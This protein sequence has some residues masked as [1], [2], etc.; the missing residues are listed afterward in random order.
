MQRCRPSFVLGYWVGNHARRGTVPGP[1]PMQQGQT[2]F[3][4]GCRVGA[5]LDE[6]PCQV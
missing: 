6:E 3:V 4:L 1:D 2:A 5:V